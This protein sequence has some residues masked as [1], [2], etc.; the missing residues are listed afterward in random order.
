MKHYLSYFYNVIIFFLLFGCKLNDSNDLTY[1][2]IWYDKPAEKWD[3]ALPLGNGRLGAMVFGNPNNERIQLNDDSL[4][5]YHDNW[6][7][8][9]G[10]EKDLLD[11]RKHLL[12]KDPKSADS[13]IVEKFSNKSIILSHQTLG[14]LFL[15]W[16]HQKISDYR[17][18][19]D[20]NTAIST[21]KYKT[22]GY[23][24]KQEVFVSHPNQ[25]IVIEI[26][27]EHPEG[28]NGTIQLNR[29]KDEGVETVSLKYEDDKIIMGG[30]VTQRGGKFRELPVVIESGVKFET[31][32]TYKN[33]FGSI[34]KNGQSL[35]V[36][37]VKKLNLFIASNSDFY[38]NDYSNKNKREI[39]KTIKLN[40][41]KIKED[42]I[43]D[44]QSFFNR[45]KLNLNSDKKLQLLTTFERL[46]KVRKGSI[47]NGLTKILYDYGR[48]L[49]IS[50]SR[51][52]TLPANLQGLW[53]NHIAAPWNADYHLNINLQMN[54]W[55]AN[56]T[57]LHE[58]NFPLFDYIDRLVENG[59]KTAKK[60]FGLRGSVIPHASDLWAKTWLRARTAY[61]GSSFGA[62]GWLMQHY[63]YHYEF[64]NDIDFLK[65]RAFPAIQEIA[66]FYSDWLIEDPRDKTL[67]SAPSTSPENQYYDLNGEKVA[68]CLGSAKDQQIIYETFTNYL[69]A[70]KIIGVENFL[71][72]KIKEQLKRL[73]PGFVIGEDGRILEWDREYKEVEPG[74]RHMSHLYGFHPGNQITIDQNPE[75]FK[76][77]KKTVDYRL[78]NGGGRT[79]WSRAWLIN[80]S[81]RL[82][83]GEMAF[84][85]IQM[86]FKNSLYT[87]LFD[88]HPPF[89][90]DGNF[91]YTAGVTE[92]LLQSHEKKGIRL[93]P[94]LP[95]SWSSGSVKGLI[96]RNNII[97]NMKWDNNEIKQVSL[98]TNSD[99]SVAVIYKNKIFNFNLKKNE[100]FVHKF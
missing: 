82:L 11:I 57:G 50:S 86:L 33:E 85:N 8:A 21:T 13:L 46:E 81:A 71:T 73:R 4:W 12:N 88:A 40:I 76:A 16:N 87:N 45:V 6:N 44:H 97:I 60:N 66:Q 84:E 94:A 30:E 23:S 59:K 34:S 36:S 92:M 14:D 20:L 67:V 47:D 22:D 61:W 38:T 15:N 58:L 95:D 49:L 26:E 98:K 43:T 62:G 74:H 64:T 28:L 69:K 91:G 78:N 96:A 53:N 18:S 93:L 32:L 25:I 75:L 48:Y 70:S 89:Q 41:K 56:P 3:E 39:A 2:T 17:R 68:T 65:N 35:K 10:T 24:V 90:I 42:H 52:G 99:K 77:V 9:E 72:R 80:I 5:P 1:Q 51:V 55:L 63:W 31:L 54:Y 29:P 79:G 7:E 27:S 100:V 19:L 83:D 37:G